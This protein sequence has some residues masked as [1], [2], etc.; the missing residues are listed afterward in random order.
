MSSFISLIFLFLI[1]SFCAYTAKM[2][3]RHPQRW[4][5]IGV[6]IGALGLLLLYLLPPKNRALASNSQTP[7]PDKLLSSERAPFEDP[8]PLKRVSTPEKL[9][10][11]L[12]ENQSRFGPM[13]FQRLKDIWKNKEI[14]KETY[15]WN[16]EME[17]WM[18][19]E[20]AGELLSELEGD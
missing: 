8:K 5:I 12:D 14:Q 13:S 7:L 18:H 15:V 17:N 2:R 4:F 16:E 3:G 19:I 1:G 20:D 9:W 11:Y 6:L 10:Y